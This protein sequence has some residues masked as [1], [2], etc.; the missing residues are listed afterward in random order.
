M[1]I[2]EW[3]AFSMACYTAGEVSSKLWAAKPAVALLVLMYASYVGSVTGWAM[4]L[5]E[6]NELARMS[7]IW[8]LSAAIV[9]VLLGVAIFREHYS[10][11]HWAGFGLA[12]AAVYLLS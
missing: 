3:L 5:A 9:S 11:E 2:W 4:M 7:T 12:L 10:L 1:G 6:R 8:S